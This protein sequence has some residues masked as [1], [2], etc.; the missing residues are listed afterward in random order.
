MIPRA[1]VEMLIERSVGLAS[2]LDRVNLALAYASGNP[3]HVKFDRATALLSL[4]GAACRVA[5]HALAGTLQSEPTQEF[6][7]IV[8]RTLNLL[9]QG[10]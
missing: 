6:M 4:A 5:E 9:R 3:E 8:E 10:K 1:N 2:D 7:A